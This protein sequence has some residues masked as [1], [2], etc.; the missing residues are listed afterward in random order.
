M[1]RACLLAVLGLFV[2]PARTAAAAPTEEVKSVNLI[3]WY[4]G[5]V[6]GTG[7]YRV[8]DKTVVQFRI[9]FAYAPK[10]FQ[11]RGVEG[12]LL[13]PVSIGFYDFD[14]STIFD[15]KIAERVGTFSFLPGVEF[16]VPV[17]NNWLLR[18]F[19]NLGGGAEYSSGGR[20]LIYAVGLKSRR[21]WS[22]GG[23]EFLLGGEL[24]YA[25][26]RTNEARTSTL[27]RIGIGGNALF[28]LGANVRGRDL[29]WGVHLIYRYYFNDL[30]SLIPALTRVE[31]VEIDD[32]VEVALTLGVDRP[33]KLFGFGLD[34][35][36]VGFVYGGDILGIRLVTGFPF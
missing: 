23:T 17:G 28:P 2:L 19:G 33:V 9:P 14:L 30:E 15:E 34:R 22:R 16:L 35:L 4:Y 12:K 1:A 20:A 27:S 3:D 24:Q 8:N 21:S 29:N 25:G 26:Y 31:T 5:A 18:P 7:V 13:L 6:Y 11:V 10:K 36:G 32:E